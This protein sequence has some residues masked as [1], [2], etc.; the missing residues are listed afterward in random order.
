MRTLWRHLQSYYGGTVRLRSRHLRTTTFCSVKLS[1]INHISFVD[2][3]TCKIPFSSDFGTSR[4]SMSICL[5]VRCGLIVELVGN[6]GSPTPA[7][8]L[9]VTFAHWGSQNPTRQRITVQF[10]GRTFTCWLRAAIELVD[11]IGHYN[12]D[13]KSIFVGC[14]TARGI[15]SHFLQDL[16]CHFGPS[17]FSPHA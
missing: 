6:P 5:W 12:S 4:A 16:V 3:S 7:L 14:R 15:Y 1:K 11:S 17:A 9:N 2:N 10:F 13:F 8:K